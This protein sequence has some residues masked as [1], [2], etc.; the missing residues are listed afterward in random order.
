MINDLDVL[1]L[2]V[3]FYVFFLTIQQILQKEKFL[4]QEHHKKDKTK[5]MDPFLSPPYFESIKANIS[6][7]ILIKIPTIN[8]FKLKS[9]NKVGKIIAPI[10]SNTRLYKKSLNFCFCLSDIFIMFN[11]AT[12]YNKSRGF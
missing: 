11:I 9:W 4:C 6:K 7:I 1:F 10:M 2:N 12:L 3:L 5:S 8:R